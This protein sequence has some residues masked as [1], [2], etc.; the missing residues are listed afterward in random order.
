[1]PGLLKFGPKVS[2]ATA[3]PASTFWES[4]FKSFSAAAALV[5]NPRQPR[6]EPPGESDLT[7]SKYRCISIYA[8]RAFKPAF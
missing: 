4:T 3:A 8:E 1:M 6:T 5:A 7:V 2:F